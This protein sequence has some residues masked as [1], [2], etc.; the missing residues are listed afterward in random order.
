M[1]PL[2]M[3]TN[4]FS[5]DNAKFT[6]CRSGTSGG[7]TQPRHQ[8]GACGSQRGDC[9]VSL[10]NGASGDVGGGTGDDDA[11]AFG[12][13]AGEIWRGIFPICGFY[14]NIFAVIVVWAPTGK[15]HRYRKIYQIFDGD[16]PLLP[17]NL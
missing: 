11:N 3:G 7:A 6:G 10:G 16:I 8:N 12:D 5:A 14:D 9:K 1:L 17:L 15:I 2:N 4:N 13:G